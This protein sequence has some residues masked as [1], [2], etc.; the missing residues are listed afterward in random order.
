[1]TKHSHRGNSLLFRSKT[2]KFLI[3]LLIFWLGREM[4]ARTIPDFHPLPEN[5]TNGKWTIYALSRNWARLVGTTEELV[6]EAPTI[7]RAKVVDYRLDILTR[8]DSSVRSDTYIFH[9]LEVLDVYRGDLSQGDI[10]EV[11]QLKGY[12]TYTYLFFRMV[13]LRLP[14]PPF[15]GPN[16]PNT[17]VLIN[18]GDE[19]VLFLHEVRLA[20]WERGSSDNPIRYGMVT[21][22]DIELGFARQV[23]NYRWMFFNP[24]QSAYYYT[25]EYLRGENFVFQPVNPANNLILT[26]ADLENLTN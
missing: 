25:P 11:F 8:G 16:F 6:E 17:P 5:A 13:R 20:S 21:S 19:V 7:I 10:I 22:W 24:I 15:R 14:P 3:V 23:Y 9:K 12:Q 2:L 1:M 18:V 26:P 4:H